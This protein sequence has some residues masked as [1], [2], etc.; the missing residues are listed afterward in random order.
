MTLA[1]AITA[2]IV[3][4]L[5]GMTGMEREVDVKHNDRRER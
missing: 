1:Q 2:I 4:L 5:V 3:L